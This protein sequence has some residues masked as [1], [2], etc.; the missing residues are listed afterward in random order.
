MK[1]KSTKRPIKI[2]AVILLL[3]NLTQRKMKILTNGVVLNEKRFFWA[4]K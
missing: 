2:P 1:I 3:S 4:K